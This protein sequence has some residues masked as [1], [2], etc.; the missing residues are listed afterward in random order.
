MYIEDKYWNNY[1]G[2]TDDSLT[3]V[4]YLATKQKK[5]SSVG[6]IFE[7]FELDTL[8]GN[9]KN[10]E[11][12]LMFVD[13]WKYMEIC[14]AI[15]LIIDLAALLL[16][17]KVNKIVNL[18]ELFGGDL[19]EITIPDVSITA[20]SKEHEIIN[21]VLMDFVAEPLTYDL[22]EMVPKKDMLEMAAVCK[23]LRKELY[24]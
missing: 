8:N 17:C 15:D 20:T 3:L 13:S 1:I 12:S 19:E 22:N 6:E 21:K 9:F 10:Q 11:T 14:Y 4:E 23:N 5:E 2:D 7:D 18:C 16:E 24:E